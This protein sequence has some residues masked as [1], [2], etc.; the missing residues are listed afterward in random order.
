MVERFRA[1]LSGQAVHEHVHEIKSFVPQVIKSGIVPLMIKSCKLPHARSM[2]RGRLRSCGV[3]TLKFC[4][5]AS[6]RFQNPSRWTVSISNCSAEKLDH[7]DGVDSVLEVE[8]EVYSAD[9]SSLALS[10]STRS[11]L[12]V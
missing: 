9:S 6:E 1:T 2:Q 8:L 7:A 3:E 10:V 11:A 5:V 12:S 4:E